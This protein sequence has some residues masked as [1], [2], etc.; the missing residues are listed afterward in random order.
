MVRRLGAK[1]RAHL[2]V[3]QLIKDD[4]KA[5]K[6]AGLRARDAML[7]DLPRLLAGH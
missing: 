5:E 6:F 4:A 2:R 1:G 7:A 3:R